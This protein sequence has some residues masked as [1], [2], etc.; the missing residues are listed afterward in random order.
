M[1]N[2]MESKSDVLVT[3]TRVRQGCCLYPLLFAIYTDSL[4]S[5]YDNVYV[6][7]YADDTAFV[8]LCNDNYP[9]CIDNYTFEIEETIDWCNRHFLFIT[10]TKTYKMIVDFRT[11]Q[12]HD[13]VT[14][15]NC[16]IEVVSDSNYLGLT[17]SYTHTWDTRITNMLTKARQRLYYELCWISPGI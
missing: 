12:S 9:Q 17:I 8:G 6:F 16:V 10:G 1:C 15:D 14:T 4:S 5:R 11:V 2:V 3:N 7:K 13:P